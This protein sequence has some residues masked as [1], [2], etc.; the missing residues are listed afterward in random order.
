MQV[1]F[2]EI[3]EVNHNLW[4]WQATDVINGNIMKALEKLYL[5]D[6]LIVQMTLTFDLLTPKQ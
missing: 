3:S 4:P 2:L 1:H 5:A 6:T